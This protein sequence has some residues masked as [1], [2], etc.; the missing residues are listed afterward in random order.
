MAKAAVESSHFQAHDFPCLYDVP[1]SLHCLQWPSLSNRPYAL[2]SNSRN[3]AN[4]AKQ[5]LDFLHIDAIAGPDTGNTFDEKAGALRK[6]SWDLLEAADREEGTVLLD[7]D[8]RRVAE[9]VGSGIVITLTY[10]MAIYRVILYGP[11]PPKQGVSAASNHQASKLPLLLTKTPLPLTKR[12]FTFLLDTFDI[13]IL[14][15]KLP[16]Y[17]LHSTLESYIKILYRNISSMAPASRRAFLE[18]ALK[19]LRISLSF[20]API[21]PH[22]RNIDADIPAETVCNLIEASVSGGT[23]FMRVLALHLEH[24]TG[25]PLPPPADRNCA[26]QEFEQ[27]ARVSKIVC[28]AFALSGDGRFKIMERAYS[29]AAI[30]NLE[31]VVREANQMVLAAL[32]EEAVKAPR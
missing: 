10:D 23:S 2:L 25:M 28:H 27:L 30:G 32:L 11:L 12:L 31:H 19:D 29:A 5:L 4:R 15:L 14:H 8:G 1:W 26:A 6:C 21:A 17:L 9:E 7:N 24:H 20:S 22:L 13:G 16:E 3:R 18:G